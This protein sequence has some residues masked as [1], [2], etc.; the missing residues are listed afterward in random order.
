MTICFTQLYS[1][2]VSLQA[3]AEE[4]TPTHT[5]IP[6]W[7]I[8]ALPSRNQCTRC[9]TLVIKNFVIVYK[10]NA[11]DTVGI[12]PV[13]QNMA[14]CFTQ[15]YLR[16]VSIVKNWRGRTKPSIATLM[17]DCSPTNKEPMYRL[18]RFS[19]QKFGTTS[20]TTCAGN[21]LKYQKL[22]YFT[23]YNMFL[24]LLQFS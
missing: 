14:I 2:C 23:S 8:V 21:Y 7:M 1:R 15:L 6:W 5:V 16:C 9:Y 11:L 20:N 18:F 22:C 3:R 4:G 10:Q 12:Y 19:H 13:R 17:D 24:Q